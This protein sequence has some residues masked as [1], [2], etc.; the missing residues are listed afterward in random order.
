MMRRTKIVYAVAWFMCAPIVLGVVWQV[1]RAM[2]VWS[3]FD[4]SAAG[5][6]A[7]FICSVVYVVG[8][9]GLVNFVLDHKDTK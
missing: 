2:L 4:N 7:F 1:W 6:T 9:F 5:L 8:V 3:G